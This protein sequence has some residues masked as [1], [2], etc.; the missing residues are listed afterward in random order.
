MVDGSGV[1]CQRV[2]TRAATRLQRS[3]E[4]RTLMKSKTLL[5]ISIP[6]LL[7]AAV[8]AQPHDDKATSH[9]MSAN[10]LSL[11]GAEHV[12]DIAHTA[13]EQRSS[14]GAIAVVD[15]GGHLIALHRLDGTFPAASAVAIDKART[16]A[17]FRK[18]TSAF[19]D[20]I[21]NGRVALVGVQE[22]TPLQG[23]IPIIVDGQVVGAIGVSGAHTAQEDEEI[24]KIGAGAIAPTSSG[25]AATK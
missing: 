6:A 14:G 9:V 15:A 4:E 13:A 7:A 10:V 12:I 21:K 22:M 25:L 20:S 19:E 8:F 1:A 17:I 16:A 2:R 3:I 11:A 23:G 5:L 18:P 24:A